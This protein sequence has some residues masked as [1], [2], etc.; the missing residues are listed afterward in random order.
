MVFTPVTPAIGTLEAPV[1]SAL[2]KRAYA[3]GLLLSYTLLVTGHLPRNV[4]ILQVMWGINKGSISSLT[5]HIL[6]EHV[7]RLLDILEK[8]QDVG[9]EGNLAPFNEH[10]I[11]Y[12][13]VPA[14][15]SSLLV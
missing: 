1:S 9:P 12:L 8:L 14:S 11:A 15:V 7:P 5:K 10:F 4:S 13:G 3:L 2:L 6:A